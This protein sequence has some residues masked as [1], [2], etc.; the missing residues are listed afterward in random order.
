MG[1][2][3]DGYRDRP[4]GGR[5]RCTGRY[6]GLIGLCISLGRFC[7]SWRRNGSVVCSTR[8][9]SLANCPII[10]FFNHFEKRLG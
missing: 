1:F 4:D 8:I 3:L 7:S 9:N 2:N 6:F 10:V 5:T